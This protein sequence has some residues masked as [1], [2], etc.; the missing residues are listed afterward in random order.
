MKATEQNRAD[1]LILYGSPQ[2]ARHMNLQP[3]SGVLVST[4]PHKTQQQGDYDWFCWS[5]SASV[6]IFL[7]R[8]GL[9]NKQVIKPKPPRV[10]KANKR[11]YIHGFVLL[12]ITL[13]AH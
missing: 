13:M 8:T 10:A 1:P 3:A 4:A 7:C 5:T 2:E 6:P 11:K 9:I 12:R